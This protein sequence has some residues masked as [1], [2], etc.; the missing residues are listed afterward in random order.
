MN[1]TSSTL[2]TL[3]DEL[4]AYFNRGCTKNLDYRRKQLSGLALFLKECETEIE[5]ALYEDLHKSPIEAFATEINLVAAEIKLNLK[6]LSAWTKPKK[7]PTPLGT[8]PGTS[9]IYPEPLGLVL[10]IAP[11][12]YPLQL[13]LS[14]LIGAIAAGNC[15]IIKPS[16]LAAATSKL[17]QEKL[18]QYLDPA[19]VR[20]VAGGVEETTAL[21]AQKFDSIFYT[22]N[23][24]IGR[25]I[26]EAAA[27]NLTPVTLELGG[28][29]PCIV[30]KDADIP[31]AARRIVWGKFLNAGQTCVAPDYVLAH[32]D[33]KTELLE[34]MEQ[35]LI[36]FFGVNPETSKDYGRIINEHHFQRL[37]HLIPGNGKIIV[38]GQADK[39]TNYIA[40][41]ILSHAP[42]DSPLMKE[43][44][45]GPIL[46]IIPIKTI[47][48][49]ISYINTQPKPLA[50]YA[51]T[52]QKHTKKQIIEQ[53]SSGSVCIN[54]VML[55]LTV[56]DL[57][58]GGVGSSGM[59]A[60]H[61]HASF[62][63]FSHYK[64]VLSKP[65]WFDPS[66]AYPPYHK[67]LKLVLRWMM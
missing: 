3:T 53:T 20:V 24:T 38:G 63:T 62:K 30:D 60:Y 65:T 66:I 5:Q 49:A 8:K 29:S 18:P 64:S 12:N 48:E 43:E 44:I 52:N 51:F 35:S 33:I 56:P 54:H 55:Q 23:G 39:N 28:K 15:A 58:F 37:M 19:S 45:F 61:G 41:T 31:V 1:T 50:L 13:T 11:W 21:L 9:L 16:E 6:K 67:L 47:T 10:I 7:V 34:H 27:K 25:I 42:M 4:R 14:P 59:G 32:E 46:P 26:L 36:E 2:A 57:P 17:L 40:P 22:G